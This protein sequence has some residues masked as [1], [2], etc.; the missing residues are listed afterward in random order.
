M[1]LICL[2]VLFVLK[3]LSDYENMDRLGGFLELGWSEKQRD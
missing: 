3:W 1:I 2:G